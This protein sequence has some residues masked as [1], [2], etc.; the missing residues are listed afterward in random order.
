M[1]PETMKQVQNISRIF[2][3]YRCNIKPACRLMSSAV[4]SDSSPSFTNIHQVRKSSSPLCH[5]RTE[6]STPVRWFGQP[7]AQTHPHLIN[8]GEVTPNITKEEYRHR[9]A[10]LVSMAR[11][12]CK[13]L[14]SADEHLFVFPSACRLYMTHDIPYPFRQNSD[15]LYLCGFQEPNSV[16]VIHSR[17][18]P[19]SSAGDH[20]SIL[21]VPKKDAH[22]EL[23]EGPCSGKEGA[24]ELTGVD[25]AY[26]SNDLE[27]FLYG[28]CQE[29]DQFML[30]YD[31]V[32]PVQG[33]F[34]QNTMSQVIG[35]ERHKAVQNS[36]QL[37]HSLRV[38]KS[39]AEVELMKQSVEIASEAFVDVMKF[40]RP[41][42]NS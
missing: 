21:F 39:A 32:S 17:N 22:R 18:S 4:L 38:K 42:V 24:V 26:N 14:K 31:Y 12:L 16:L 3:H 11:S 20:Q 25:C 13:G 5:A 29:H 37:M 34:H 40:S 33:S 36:R 27:K 19:S 23:W 10:M 9:R 30:W 28:F 1:I 7:V 35:Q 15:F 6:V 2:L 8:N 41:E